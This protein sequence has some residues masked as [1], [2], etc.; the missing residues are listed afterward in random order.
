MIR[1][2]GFPH[3]DKLRIV[4]LYRRTSFGTLEAELTIIDS[5]IYNQPWTTKGTIA[6]SPGT[7]IWEYLCLTSESK[8]FDADYLRPEVGAK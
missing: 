5:E 4:D 8:R 7:E 3:S 1:P 2:W 6:L